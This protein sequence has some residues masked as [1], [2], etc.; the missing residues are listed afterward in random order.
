MHLAS[1]LGGSF[2]LNFKH[3][4][5][6][7]LLLSLPVFLLT[8]ISAEEYHPGQF[9]LSGSDFD[10]QSS[11]TGIFITSVPS[12]KIA[13]VYYGERIVQAG[14]AIPLDALSNLTLKTDCVTKHNTAVT[15]RT[16][17]NGHASEEKVLKLSIIPPKN[18]PPVATNSQFETYKNIPNS[19]MLTASDQESGTLEYELVDHPK[20]GDVEINPDGT[21]LYTP[22]QN[23]VG[24]DYFTFRVKDSAGQYS[25][26]AKVSV[27]IRK[28]TE[29]EVYADMQGDPDAFSAMWLKDQKIFSGSE[30][31]SHL[32]FSPDTAVSRGEFLVMVMNW[33]DADVSETTVSTGFTDELQTPGWMQPYIASAL[34]AGIISGTVNDDGVSFRPN[35]NITKAEAAVMLQNIGKLPESDAAEVFSSQTDAIPTWATTAASAL[36]SAGIDL[37]ISSAAEVLTRR[38]AAKVLYQMDQLD[39][40][41]VPVRA[42]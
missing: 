18:T 38:D 10:A 19:G 35:E 21:F 37:N 25:E 12:S 42:E 15:Y 26:P 14:D 6:L 23:K 40:Q 27:K 11:D 20:R 32:Y 36:F 24:N 33:L 30:I 16:V 1:E 41:T 34:H 5:I 9:S 7:L 31:G 3:S 13:T 29:K 4:V 39:I 8:P 17:S 2:L 22:D 28:P